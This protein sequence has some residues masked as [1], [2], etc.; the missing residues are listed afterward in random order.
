MVSST[1][2]CDQTKLHNSFSLVHDSIYPDE[3]LVL[4]YVLILPGASFISE[5][6]RNAYKALLFIVESVIAG[7]VRLDRSYD[8]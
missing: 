4:C 3:L 7:L 2:H 6:F 1:L 8:T 5:I